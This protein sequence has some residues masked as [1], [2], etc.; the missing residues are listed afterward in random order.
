MCPI[1]S[2]VLATDNDGL[3]AH[4]DWC[5]SKSAILE[6]AA[7]KE[8]RSTMKAVDRA[9]PKKPPSGSSS[10]AGNCAAKGDAKAA[11]GQLF[12]N[13]GRTSKPDK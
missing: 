6:A 9:K 7:T 11:W 2:K 12:A 13:S 3:N 5:L 8:A 10:K 1:C 4:V